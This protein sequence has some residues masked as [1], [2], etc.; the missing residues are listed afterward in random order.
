MNHKRSNSLQA[1]V[2][3]P[4]ILEKNRVKRT[5]DKL[6]L[7]KLNQQIINKEEL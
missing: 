3:T 5:N 7:D 1:K 4:K 2:Q 6:L